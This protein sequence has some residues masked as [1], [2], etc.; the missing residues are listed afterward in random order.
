VAINSYRDLKVWQDAM[1]LVQEVYALSRRFPKSEQFSLRSRLQRAV[2]SIPS[3]IA[4]GHAR[5]RTKE[6]LRFVSIA[7][8]SLAETETQIML[9]ERLSYASSNEAAA[10]L[11]RM[12]ELGR[13]LR[14]LEQ[15]LERK[16]ND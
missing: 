11:G 14:R 12:D 8:G 16:I 3:N 10:M 13:M 4:E 6:Y 1:Q 7:R 15:A 9:A 5:S 2:V